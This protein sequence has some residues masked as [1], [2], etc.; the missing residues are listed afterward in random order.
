MSPQ[1]LN[2]ILLFVLAALYLPVL[3]NLIERRSGQEE[4]ARYLIIYLVIGLL[5]DGGEGLWRGGQLPIATPRVAIDFQLYGALALSFLLLLTVLSFTRRD[6][7]RWLILGAVWA[8]GFVVIL[9][10]LLRL[11]DVIWTNGRYALT[12]DRLAPTWAVIGWIVFTLGGIFNVRAAYG[13]ARQ[14]LLRNRLN[15]WTPVF[16]LAILND[17]F[18]IIGIPL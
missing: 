7:K 5:L 3:M 1:T 17:I 16:L 11:P 18:I 9:P 15:Y 10:N 6:T 13:R 2:L 4:A 14:P 12:L 8:L